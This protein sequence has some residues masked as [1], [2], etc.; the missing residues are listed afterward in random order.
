M[1]WTGSNSKVFAALLA[2]VIFV[3]TVA[4]KLTIFPAVKETYFVLNQRSLQT[5]PFGLVVVRPTHFSKSA[6]SGI[7]WDTVPRSGKSTPR[8]LGRNVSLQAL[9]GVAYGQYTDRVVLPPGAPKTNFDFLV[10]AAGDQPKK[11]QAAVRQRLGLVACTEMRSTKVLALRISDP[12][13]PRLKVSDARSDQGVK[14]DGQQLHGTHLRVQDLAASVEQTLNLPVV[15]ETE[16][17][18][19]YDFT[20]NLTLQTQ[21]QLQNE[22]TAPTAIRQILGDLG[23]TV[24]SD[25]DQAEVLVVKSAS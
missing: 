16:L 20:V 13:L 21:Q 10:T 5:V 1:A 2:V 18:N 12:D 8:V 4:V 3:T 23:L 22:A 6:R 15:D 19:Y 17:T 14:F 25:Q 7:L 9:M 11:L 24:E